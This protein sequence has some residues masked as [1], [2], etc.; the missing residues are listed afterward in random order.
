VYAKCVASKKELFVGIG[1]S[2][3]RQVHRSDVD[4]K[5]L[6]IARV[7]LLGEVCYPLT[8]RIHWFVDN[9]QQIVKP[10]VERAFEVIF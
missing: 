2:G 3:K 10:N 6:S 5:P 7:D 1:R 8:S 4:E 9:F